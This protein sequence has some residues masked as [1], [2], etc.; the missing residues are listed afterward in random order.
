MTLLEQGVALYEATVKEKS[1]SSPVAAGL[2]QYLMQHFGPAAYQALKESDRNRKPTQAPAPVAQGTRQ[3]SAPAP[4]LTRFAHPATGKPLP[5]AEAKRGKF[6]E[7]ARPGNAEDL[8]DS[9]EP[10]PMPIQVLPAQD[11]S[12]EPA[13]AEKVAAADISL[14]AAFTA[15]DLA[16]IKNSSAVTV[17][18]KYSDG[19]IR[20]WLMVE[21][22]QYN[23]SHTVRQLAALMIQRLNQK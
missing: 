19:M 15:D 12:S 18:K 11:K 13:T 8:S 3:V 22:V 10:L 7:T 5:L 21:G 16:E 20:A 4:K 9:I 17:A 2:R 1:H 23:E 14:P 6:R